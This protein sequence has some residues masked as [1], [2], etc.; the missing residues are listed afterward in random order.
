MKAIYFAC[1]AVLVLSGCGLQ[2]APTPEA[3]PL[4]DARKGFQ[5]KIIGNQSAKQTVPTP[6]RQL[7]RTV[8]YKSPVGLLPAYLTPDPKDGQQHP[9][10]I[11]ITGGDCNSIDDGCWTEGPASNDQ[12]ASAFR[13]AGIAMLFPSLRGG[14]DN[15]GQKESFFGEVDD[16]LAAADFLAAQPF[17]D[18]HRLYLGGHST[19]GTVALLVAECSDRFR[20]VFAFGP[21]DDVSH[22]GPEYIC[23]D[24]SNPRETALRSPGRWLASV[25]KPTFVLEGKSQGNISS[26]NAMAS[27]CTNPNVHFIPVTGA[28]HFSILAPATRVIAEKILRDDGPTSTLSVTE[29]E[30]MER[31]AR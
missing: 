11:W 4:V 9:A 3:E 27:T 20:V 17:V 15:V 24:Q 6:P 22:Y 29:E 13:K 28:T 5:T 30:V 12:S 31:A 23:F 18:P 14:N 2:P 10:I 7:F 21:T 19:G 16:V 25:K 1:C 26:L 8:H